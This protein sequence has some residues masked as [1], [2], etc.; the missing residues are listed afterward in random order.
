MTHPRCPIRDDQVD[1]YH[2][3]GAIVVEGLLDDETRLEMKRALAEWVEAS[4]GV[5]SHDDV[6]DLV[7]GVAAGDPDLEEIAAGLRRLGN[8]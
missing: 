8:P 2:A 1:R 5:T 4:R 6:Y 3:D 7:I